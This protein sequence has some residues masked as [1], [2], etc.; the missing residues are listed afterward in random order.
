MR[1]PDVIG[2]YNVVPWDRGLDIRIR[3]EMDPP[4]LHLSPLPPSLSLFS[5]P[6]CPFTNAAKRE[7][8]PDAEKSA[9]FHLSP[10][11]LFSLTP[12]SLIMLVF[13]PS[14]DS[15]RLSFSSRILRIGLALPR[16][17]QRGNRSYVPPRCPWSCAM[18][19]IYLVIRFLPRLTDHV[20]VVS[21]RHF[22]QI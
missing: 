20:I 13:L 5:V 16:I 19:G 10:S 1:K 15:E 4:F 6:S 17:D 21:E 14:N 7:S 11:L 8:D 18:R 2:L 22:C 9:R 3:A 12:D